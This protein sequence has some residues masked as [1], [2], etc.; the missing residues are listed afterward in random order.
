MRTFKDRNKL[1]WSFDLNITSMDHVQQQLGVNMMLD[2]RLLL[3]LRDNPILLRDVLFVL[4]KD[5]VDKRE[6]TLEEFGEALKGNAIM[7]A[8]DALIGELVDFCPSPVR[9][10]EWKEAQRK[11]ARGDELMAEVLAEKYPKMTDEKLK[12]LMEQV[13]D[14]NEMLAVLE[15]IIKGTFETSTSAPESSESTPAPSPS[16]N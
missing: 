11:T 3:H 6:V 4:C 5:E 15:S 2:D 7:E 9:R 16:S 13:L 14:S 1:E 10:E 8:T 12:A